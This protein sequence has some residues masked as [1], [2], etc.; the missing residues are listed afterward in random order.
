MYSRPTVEDH[1]IGKR[2]AH[3]AVLRDAERWAITAMAETHAAILRHTA[4]LAEPYASHA[5]GRM[6]AEPLADGGWGFRI[7]LAMPAI[8]A[9]AGVALATVI[10]G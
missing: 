4:G 7:A 3:L 8:V 6:A 2:V 9:V 1:E 10:R 5:T